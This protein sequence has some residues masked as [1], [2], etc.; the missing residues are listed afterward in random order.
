MALVMD[1]GRVEAGLVEEKGVAE[2]DETRPESR[3]C[4]EATKD[5]QAELMSLFCTSFRS[6]VRMSVHVVT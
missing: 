4:D 2:G 1:E 6:Y 5:S 3:I